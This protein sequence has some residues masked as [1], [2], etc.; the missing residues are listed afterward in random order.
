[1]RWKSALTVLGLVLPTGLAELHPR[2]TQEKTL[3]M[4]MP[5]RRHMMGGLLQSL[6]FSSDGKTYAVA[7]SSRPA[8]DLYETGD[9][10]VVRS[11][12]P[13]DLGA[14]YAIA[15]SP[16]GELLCYAVLG[17]EKQDYFNGIR[18]WH[19]GKAKTIFNLDQKRPVECLTVSYDGKL[20]ASGDGKGAIK[21]WDLSKGQLI[22]TLEEHVHVS[23]L[24]FS[25]DGKFLA[26]GGHDRRLFLWDV[27]K[28]KLAWR[29]HDRKEGLFAT[30]AFNKDGTKLFVGD[31]TG[32][33]EVWDLKD[34]KL[35]S[36]LSVKEQ[37]LP[38]ASI[39]FSSSREIVA[40][41]ATDSTI[42][43]WMVSNGKDIHTLKHS[44]RQKVSHL[45]FGAD[46]HYLLSGAQ[47]AN[48][49]EG[50]QVEVLVWHL[51]KVLKPK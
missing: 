3:P 50:A 28:L 9:G 30:V 8:I 26:S 15:F 23:C 24:A 41:G 25:P 13:R 33:L 5:F 17:K 12:P 32:K 48:V 18:V 51:A 38:L 4:Q 7:V 47:D 6:S 35:I 46:D 37:P 27:A 40:T 36:V 29:L 2:H 42:K 44:G 19:I 21:L 31:A 16:D 34:R 14:N 45:A 49:L 10:K 43:L 39:A 11:S 20:L 22:A 1:M